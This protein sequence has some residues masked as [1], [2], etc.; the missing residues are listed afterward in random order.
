[1]LKKKRKGGGGGKKYKKYNIN[2]KV[3]QKIQ[4]VIIIGVL[5]IRDYYKIIV[6][7]GR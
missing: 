5:I 3:V 6:W 7:N 1:M 4:K 2:K